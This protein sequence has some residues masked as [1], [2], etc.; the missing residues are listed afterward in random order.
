[1]HIKNWWQ[2]YTLILWCYDVGYVMIIWGACQY[3]SLS[4]FHTILP[5]LI[6]ITLSWSLSFWTFL[7]TALPFSLIFCSLFSSLFSTLVSMTVLDVECSCVGLFVTGPLTMFILLLLL[8]GCLSS[9]FKMFSNGSVLIC[10]YSWSQIYCSAEIGVG[11]MCCLFHVI[12]LPVLWC[13]CGMI[14]HDDFDHLSLLLCH[15]STVPHPL[16]EP[17]Q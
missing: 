5:Y 12:S 2:N 16:I 8:P 7:L 6:L 3:A 11:S 1:M 14:C 13:R 4:R 10:L 17:L 15:G 9:W